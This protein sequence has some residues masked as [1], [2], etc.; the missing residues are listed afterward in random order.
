MFDSFGV[1]SGDTTGIF[2]LFPTDM[3]TLA[4]CAGQILNAK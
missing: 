3:K 2:L 1:M 4:Q